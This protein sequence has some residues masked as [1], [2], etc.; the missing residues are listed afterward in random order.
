MV[1]HGQY[2]TPSLFIS[3]PQNLS[4]QRYF[5]YYHLIFLAF[6]V[7]AFLDMLHSEA[8]VPLLSSE[9]DAQP[10]MTSIST[11]LTILGDPKKSRS[12]YVIYLLNCRR[13]EYNS[14]NVHSYEYLNIQHIALKDLKA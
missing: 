2:Q 7:T 10:I 14:K 3:Y 12:Y 9:L 11:A 4:I 6:Q 1:Q 5:L 8:C 13:M